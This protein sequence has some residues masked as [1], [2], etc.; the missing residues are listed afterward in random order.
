MESI[1][2]GTKI[3]RD[4][5]FISTVFSRCCCTI[6]LTGAILLSGGKTLCAQNN[7]NEKI[8]NGNENV[9]P[10][11]SHPKSLFGTTTY[12]NQ[13]VNPS[14]DMMNKELKEDKDAIAARIKK[15]EADDKIRAKLWEK[16][17]K[18]RALYKGSSEWAVMY[19]NVDEK[20]D[21][22]FI[23][24][25]PPVFKFETVRKWYKAKVWR[26]YRRLVWNFKKVYPYAL[27]ARGII[28]EADSVLA[29][30]NFSRREKDEYIKMYQDKLF[31][32]F[33][34]PMRNLT[35]SQG[36]LLMKL[37]DRELGRTS[38][39]IIRQYRGRLSAGFWQLVARMFGSDL[40]KP[41]DKFGADRQVEELVVLYQEGSFDALYYSMFG[42]Q[43]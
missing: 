27:Q 19:Y 5:S 29:V 9:N 33:E 32:Q 6:F 42:N 35:I 17:E 41:Y 40:K 38:F 11:L 7:R 8:K 26:E 18:D 43:Y 37:I 28:H 21:T 30:S 2:E 31:K 14:G 39:Y 36:Q 22:T 3:E 10:Q 23:D 15:R 1:M 13:Q 4:I 12:G 24:W 34:K 20:G 16:V 25:L